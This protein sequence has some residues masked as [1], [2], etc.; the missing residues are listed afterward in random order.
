MEGFRSELF[1]YSETTQHNTE[2]NTNHIF[3]KLFFCS[4]NLCIFQ[5]FTQGC[6]L[7]FICIELNTIFDQSTKELCFSLFT[8]QRQISTNQQIGELQLALVHLKIEDIPPQLLRS[9]LFVFI[10]HFCNIF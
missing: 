7:T 3:P 2:L 1:A 9:V 4:A 6:K 8:N 10:A 5:Y